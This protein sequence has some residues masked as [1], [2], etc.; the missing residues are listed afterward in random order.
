MAGTKPPAGQE[1][2][3]LTVVL[4]VRDE[5]A[6]LSQVLDDL[7]A[8]L[9]QSSLEIIALVDSRSTDRS[10]QILEGYAETLARRGAGSP[11]MRIIVLSPPRCGSGAARAVGSREGQG[12][13]IGWMDADGTYSAR[14][15][16]TLAETIGTADQV[17]GVRSCD[18]GPAGPLRFFVKAGITKFVALLW[19]RVDLVDLNSGLR[20]FKRSALLEWLDE[21]PEGFSCTTTA[22]LAALNHNQTVRFCGISYSARGLGTKSKF[23]P[24]LDTARLLRVVSRQWWRKPAR[25]KD[26]SRARQR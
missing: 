22:T 7:V 23:H 10:A 25:I 16:Q 21:L 8:A 3:D 26:R 20:V 6:I 18:F 4:P 5:A 14:D 2:F 13:V 24:L 15:L 1:S 9:S 19:R 17:V 12:K 11:V